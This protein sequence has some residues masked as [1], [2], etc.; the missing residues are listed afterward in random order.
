MMHHTEANDSRPIALPMDERYTIA[1]QVCSRQSLTADAADVH[2][3]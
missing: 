1:R 2:C 3:K